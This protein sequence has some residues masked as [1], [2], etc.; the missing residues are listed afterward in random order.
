VAD[1][2]REG[3]GGIRRSRSHLEAEDA[4]HHRG[5]L[6]LV[7]PAGAGDRGL[8]LGRCVEHDRDAALGGGEQRDGCGVGRRHHRR[9]VDVGED[10]FDRHHLRQEPVEPAVELALEEDQPLPRV[11]VAR[12]ADHP[13]G[14]HGGAP[15]AAVDD[16]ETA[17]GQAGVDAEHAHAG[18]SSGSVVTVRTPVR[19]ATL[20]SRRWWSAEQHARRRPFAGRP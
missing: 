15:R 18:T 13:H 14:H 6:R 5:D 12:G 8:D 11:G 9:D 4:G 20:H 2:E 1:R 16:A 10:T 3:V 17:A 7:G 19:D